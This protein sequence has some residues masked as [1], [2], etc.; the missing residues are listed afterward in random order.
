MAL[1]GCN[2][3]QTGAPQST[4]P[5]AAQMA[6]GRTLCGQK[7]D[8]QPAP[9][10]NASTNSRELA[11]VWVGEIFASNFQNFT[12]YRRCVAFAAEDATADGKVMAKFVLGDSTITQNGNKY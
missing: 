8:Y 10:P 5:V 3:E 4:T 11:G 2:T 6:S 7:F 1:V 9:S 12:E